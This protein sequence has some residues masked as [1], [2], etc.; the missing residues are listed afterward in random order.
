MVFV[1]LFPILLSMIIS[2][3]IHIAVNSIVS[4]LQLRRIPLYMY[5]APLSILLSMDI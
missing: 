2:R 1:V 3:S 5:P 4:F